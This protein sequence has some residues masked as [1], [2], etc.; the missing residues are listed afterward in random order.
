[1]YPDP[2][3]RLHEV[4]LLNDPQ[5]VG[6]EPGWD[7]YGSCH[8]PEALCNHSQRPAL[9][10]HHSPVSTAPSCWN[11]DEVLKASQQEMPS[12]AIYTHPCE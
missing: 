6:M 5:G 4:W 8:D 9:N 11:P 1:M 10:Q 7:V 2:Q 3:S 12:I